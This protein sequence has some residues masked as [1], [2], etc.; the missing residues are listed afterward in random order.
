M[1]EQ[2][3]DAPPGPPNV[4]PAFA[5]IGRLVVVCVLATTVVVMVVVAGGM[6][7]TTGSLGEGLTLGAFTAVWGGPGFGVMVGGAVNALRED[8]RR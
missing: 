3:N 4:I 5:S 2:G 6:W 8:R 7:W 1:Y